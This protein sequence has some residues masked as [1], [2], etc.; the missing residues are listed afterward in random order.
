MMGVCCDDSNKNNNKVTITYNDSVEISN[1]NRQFLFNKSNIGQSKSRCACQ[2]IKNFNI[3]FKYD[4]QEM[5]LNNETENFFNDDFW[6]KQNFILNAV[7]NNEARKYIDT[8]CCFYSKPCIDTGTLG[9]IGSCYIFYPFKTQCFRD[10]PPVIEEQ[11]PMCT[12]KDFPYKF[13]HCIEFAK[14]IF[15]EIFEEYINDLNLLMRD[16][17]IFKSIYL[18]SIQDDNSKNEKIEKLNYIIDLFSFY[19]NK[20]INV[21]IEIILKIFSKY[22]FEKIN[23]LIKCY[24]KDYKNKDGSFYWSGNRRFPKVLEFNI[25]NDLSIMFLKSSLNIYKKIFNIDIGQNYLSN[26]DFNINKNNHH[27]KFENISMEDQFNILKNIKEEIIKKN[28]Y[29]ELIPEHYDKDNEGDSHLQFIHSFSCLRA[30]NYNIEEYKIY[31]TKVISG[32]IIPDLSTTTSSFVGFACLQLCSMILN[33]EIDDYRCVNI[34]LATNF[35]DSWIPPKPNLIVDN[36]NIING[37]SRR[38]LDKPFTVWDTIEV[39]GSLTAKE[40]IDFFEKKYDVIIYFISCENK[41]IIDPIFDKKKDYESIKF[42]YNLLIEEL[43][44]KSSK[45]SFKNKKTLEIKLTCKRKKFLILCPSIKYFIGI[46]NK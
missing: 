26:Y 40:F 28:N 7:D 45:K 27:K 31:Q 34:N 15:S 23:N 29:I 18:S 8:K 13:E 24:P 33:S 38:V 4:S 14:S 30:K 39:I 6:M 11:I 16:F 25:S 3:N 10:I 20:D 2:K 35:Y 17:D 42:K 21:L 41:K 22:F 12:L 46:K 32:K 19:Q 1:L 36:D 43:Y 37:F 5:L 9:T 44:E